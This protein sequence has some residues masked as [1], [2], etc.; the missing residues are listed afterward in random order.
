MDPDAT[1]ANIITAAANG[2]APTLL[3]AAGTLVA[4]LESGGFAPRDPRTY[5]EDD[6]AR[7]ND[8]PLP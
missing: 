2:D 6:W 4:W 3:E 8:V 5:R 7:E 1:L